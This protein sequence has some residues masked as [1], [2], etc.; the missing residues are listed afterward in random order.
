MNGDSVDQV[1]PYNRV[2]GATIIPIQGESTPI[3][4]SL[5]EGGLEARG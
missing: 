5:P 1:S 2:T 3:E 4:S